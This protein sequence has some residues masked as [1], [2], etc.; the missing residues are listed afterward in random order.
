MRIRC[1]T[2]LPL[3]ALLLA[4]TFGATSVPA[5]ESAPAPATPAPAPAASA[6]A[7]TRRFFL[8]PPFLRNSDA[9]GV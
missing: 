6:P 1:K 8:R 7:P 2:L 5:A 9:C 4:L 3:P